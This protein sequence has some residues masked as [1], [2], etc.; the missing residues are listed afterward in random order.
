MAGLDGINRKLDPGQPV[1]KNLYDL[2]PREAARIKQV[3]GSLAETISALE[4]DHDFLL[5]GGV[6]TQDLIDTW[7]DLKRAEADEVRLRPHPY[8]FKLYLDA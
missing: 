5:Q 4:R 3:P 8:E 1:D 7:I 2:S 6:F